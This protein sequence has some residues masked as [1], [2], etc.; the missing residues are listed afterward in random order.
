[1]PIE[2]IK[3]LEMRKAQRISERDYQLILNALRKKSEV[4]IYSWFINPFRRIAGVSALTSGFL[5]LII[6]SIA[7]SIAGV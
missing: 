5:I 3:L 4:S 6:L 2:E 7:G 1:M